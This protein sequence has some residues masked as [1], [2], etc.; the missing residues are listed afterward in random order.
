MRIRWW[1]LLA[2]LTAACGTE[3]ESKFDAGTAPDA[4]RPPDADTTDAALPD[5][6]PP[7]CSE[8]QAIATGITEA[9]GVAI[10]QDRVYFTAGGT[11]EGDYADGKVMVVDKMG[12][13]VTTMASNQ[14]RPMGIVVDATHVYW[15]VSGGTTAN[16]G[17]I[18]RAAKSGGAPEELASGQHDSS[19]LALDD[20]Y[21]YWLVSQSA[22][23]V[24]DGQV[25]RVPKE[26]GIVETLATDQ[27]SPI[28]IAVDATHVYWSEFLG[29]VFRVA[30]SGGTPAIVANG[31]YRANGI[32]LADDHV[33][34][35]SFFGQLYVVP[36]AGGEPTTLTPSTNTGAIDLAIDDDH[37]YWTNDSDAVL[38]AALAGS[39]YTQVGSGIGWGI[40]IDDECV[41]WALR[42]GP[43][44]EI[45]VAS[46]Y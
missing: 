30:K 34:F 11:Q 36:K 25:R 38:R 35:L 41:Y 13:Q 37:A 2:F 28:D 19:A 7:W 33:Y 5:A 1:A 3:S 9:W 12:G 18:W 32:A 23:T 4:S 29:P 14:S 17:S 22:A 45:R 26:G 24:Y 21:V 8:Q 43:D 46:K 39:D 40:A 6:L 44:S 15:A 31:N 20:G 16:S 27:D 10:D 42:A